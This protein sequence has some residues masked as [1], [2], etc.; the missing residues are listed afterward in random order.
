MS[1]HRFT[2]D[3]CLDRGY[4]IEEGFSHAMESRAEFVPCPFCK[5][6]PRP[7]TLPA[8]PLLIAILAIFLMAFLSVCHANRSTQD[9]VPGRVAHPH[10]G[11][12]AAR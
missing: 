7:S 5:P 11:P 9:R 10:D 6:E 12:P 8:W 1:D 4:T 3:H 2:C